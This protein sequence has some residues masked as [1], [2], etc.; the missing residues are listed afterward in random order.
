VQSQI[1]EEYM[2]KHIS[3][4]TRCSALAL[5]AILAFAVSS[6][7]AQT[8]PAAPAAAPAEASPAQSAPAT[9]GPISHNIKL[10][11]INGNIN[12]MVNSD[13]T[14]LFSGTA[15]AEKNKDYDVS[16]ALRAKTGAIFVFHWVGDAAHP[17]EFSKSG[18][19][20]ILKEDFSD[21][22]KG[23]H[24]AWT[25]RYYESAAGKKAQ[26]E[27][28][29]RKR[30]QLAREEKEAREKHEAKLEAEKKAEQK[31]EA[32]KELAEERQ[33]ASQQKSSGG[34]GGGIGSTIDSVVNTVGSVV[35]GVTSAV[36]DVGSFLGSIF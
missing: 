7:T 12:I 30:E 31:R 10:N 1:E 28:R 26:Y 35:S 23:H 29:Q 14:W 5:F 4:L 2:S 33:Q 32:Q 9:T 22:Q 21:F 18:Q 20:S 16:L 17:V 27:E 8:S 19:S 34:G 6:A 13:G 3:V 15:K 36:S 24:Y 25:Y 11:K